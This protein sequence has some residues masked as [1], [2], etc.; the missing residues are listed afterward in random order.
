MKT[1][2]SAN[3]RLTILQDL[4]DDITILEGRILTA[5]QTETSIALKRLKHVLEQEVR[6]RMGRN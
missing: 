1:L 6:L 5:R 3:E 4:F 2:R